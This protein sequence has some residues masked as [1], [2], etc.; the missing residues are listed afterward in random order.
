MLFHWKPH[1]DREPESS[2][3][4]V[5]ESHGHSITLVFTPYGAQVIMASITESGP[6]TDH[7]G[8]RF[9]TKDTKPG[10]DTND[11]FWMPDIE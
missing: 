3:I 2:L 11:P 8:S 5:T 9:Y 1:V 4:I 7:Q 6:D 10:S